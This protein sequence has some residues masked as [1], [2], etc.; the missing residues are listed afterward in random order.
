MGAKES[1]RKRIIWIKKAFESGM[2]QKKKD[3]D[4]KAAKENHRHDEQWTKN[5]FS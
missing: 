2:K 5:L 4:A 1:V 3:E